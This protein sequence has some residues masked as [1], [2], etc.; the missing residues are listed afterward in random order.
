[1]SYLSAILSP[2]RLTQIVD[3]GANP[4]EGDPPY[5]PMLQAGLADVTGFEPQ[6]AALAR[7]NA[8]KG[9]RERYLPYALGDGGEHTLHVT[10]MDGMTSLLEPDAEHLSLFGRFPEWGTVTAK[11]PIPTRTLD[12]I[13]EIAAM[14]YLKMDI[15][16]AERQV[17]SHATAK[18]KDTVAVQIEVSFI[19]LYKNQP[20]FGD[21]DVFMRAQG[22]LPH[23]FAEMKTWPL[24]PTLMQGKDPMGR[25]QVLEADM[26]YVRDFTRAEN[27]SVEQWK[28]LAMVA[29]HAYGSYNLA[30]RS[31]TMLIKLGALP[32]GAAMNYVNALNATKESA[33]AQNR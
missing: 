15:Q 19:S 31:V 6:A 26:L 22:F 24:T 11:F 4:C 2:A 20:S 28:H 10:A 25:Q 21:M 27:L 29:H 7:L 9:P 30:L 17:L 16:G 8:M 1:M 3:V 33:P 12:S 14:D 32:P 23:C 18:L 5:K 13:S